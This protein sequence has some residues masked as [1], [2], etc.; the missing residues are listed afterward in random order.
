M[1]NERYQGVLLSTQKKMDISAEQIRD[2][3]PT[4]GEI[5]V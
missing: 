2:L 5:V 1:P 3:I 4:S